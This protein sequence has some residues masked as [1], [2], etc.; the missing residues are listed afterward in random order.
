MVHRAAGRYATV[1][2]GALSC[3]VVV[4]NVPTHSIHHPAHH[5]VPPRGRAEKP[6]ADEVSEEDEMGASAARPYHGGACQPRI[7]T[8]R[9]HSMRYVISNPGAVSPHDVMTEKHTTRVP[10]PAASAREEVPEC[11]L[12]QTTCTGLVASKIGPPR[13]CFKAVERSNQKCMRLKYCDQ[14]GSTFETLKTPM[15]SEKCPDRIDDRRHSFFGLA[16]LSAHAPR[17]ARQQRPYVWRRTSPGQTRSPPIA[18][19]GAI[20]YVEKARATASTGFKAKGTRWLCDFG[21]YGPR[22]RFAATRLRRPPK[23]ARTE[24][25]RCWSSACGAYPTCFPHIKRE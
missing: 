15:K 17:W 21:T 14:T 3:R 24:T 10:R 9:V 7:Q 23:T 2:L 18:A 20:F 11:N 13:F 16:H 6:E 19:P 1:I 5:P 8:R 25:H 22:L 12:T 4:S